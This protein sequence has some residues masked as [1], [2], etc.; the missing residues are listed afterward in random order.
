MGELV[1]SV[2]VIGASAGGVR[3]IQ[4]L[5]GDIP[6]NFPW[7]IVC[8]LHLPQTSSVDPLMVFQRNTA[9]KVVEIEDKLP[10]EMGC[11]YFAPAGYHV[12][13]DREH[14]FSLSQDE[15]VNYSR[16][17]IDVLF[18]TTARAYADRVFGLLLTGA[19]ADGALGLKAIHD[20]GGWTL[21]QDPE[22]AEISFMPAEALRLE[23]RHLKAT[24]KNI[25]ALLIEQARLHG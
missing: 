14:L 15:P 25:P 7:P 5:L 23:P 19:N 8:V 24:L 1:G 11:V 3:A 6:G 21:V 17:S 18:E 9:L 22:D 20:G 4:Q 10:L 2:V 16:P 12:S 13:I